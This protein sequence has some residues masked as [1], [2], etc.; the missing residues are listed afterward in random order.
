MRAHSGLTL[1]PGLPTL[2]IHYGGVRETLFPSRATRASSQRQHATENKHYLHTTLSLRPSRAGAVSLHLTRPRDRRGTAWSSVVRRGPDGPA[3]LCIA[4]QRSPRPRALPL[5]SLP[6]HTDHILHANL[7]VRRP[8]LLPHPSAGVRPA[9][10]A[11]SSQARASGAAPH[12]ASPPHI[13]VSA[14]CHYQNTCSESDR[15]TRAPRSATIHSR[16]VARTAAAAA[17]AAAEEERVC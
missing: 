11:A 3:L 16:G 12:D 15:S 13:H 9:A 17:A 6:V 7:A 8:D 4:I 5:A 14:G 10:P 2:V 1:S